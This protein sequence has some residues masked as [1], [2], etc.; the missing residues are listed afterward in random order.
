MSNDFFE[1]TVPRAGAEAE[2]L[3][4]LRSH[5]SSWKS[6]I[7]P[8]NTWTET[9]DHPLAVGIRVPGL[10]GPT[11]TLWL[12]AHVDDNAPQGLRGFWGDRG[13]I[14]GSE[15]HSPHELE[16]RGIRQTPQALARQAA[17][18]FEEQLLRP[19]DR[20]DFDVRYDSNWTFTPSTRRRRRRRSP[21]DQ[22]IP[23]RRDGFAVVPSGNDI[24]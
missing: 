16:I 8:D 15:K 10:T 17:S 4:A 3:D 1:D 21:E 24:E 18:W 9:L 7:Q 12:I 14:E 11:T 19:I 23:E 20:G 5:A 13:Y 22:A 6:D 2:F